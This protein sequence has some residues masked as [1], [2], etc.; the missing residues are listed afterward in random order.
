MNLYHTEDLFEAIPV[1]D[2]VNKV[3]NSGPELLERVELVV[4]LKP[5]ASNR[6]ADETVGDQLDLF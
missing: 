3:A 4:A 5:K 6:I 2:L 1:S